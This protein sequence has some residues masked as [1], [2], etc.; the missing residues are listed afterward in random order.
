M[1]RR[2]MIHPTDPVARRLW[3]SRVALGF[4][5]QQNFAAAVGIARNTYNEYET[6]RRPLSLE[7]AR[8]LQRQ[9]GLPVEWLYDGVPN[10]LPH[11]FVV[12]LA[13]LGAFDSPAGPAVTRNGAASPISRVMRN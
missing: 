8:R 4:R 12:K 9:Y 11:G 10:R 13:A 7:S 3:W 5:D 2:S 1:A 6:A